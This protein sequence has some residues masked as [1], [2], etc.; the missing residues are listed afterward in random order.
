[1]PLI[2]PIFIPH[3][4][5]PRHCLFCNQVSISGQ[6]TSKENDAELVRKTIREWLERSRKHRKVQVAFY[7]GSFTCLPE[8][9][10]HA[11]LTAVQPFIQSGEVASIRL[12]TRPDCIDEKICDFLKEYGVKTVELGV[13]SLD[14]QVLQAA[15]R[16]HSREDSIRSAGVLKENGLRLGIQLMPGLPQENSRSWSET[17]AQV[18]KLKPD[19]IRLYPTLVI[20]GSGLADLHRNGEFLPMSMNRA[21]A[22]C[23]KAKEI[24]DEAGIRTI[25]MGLQASVSLEKELLAGPYHPSF[26]EFVVA[27]QWFRRARRLLALCPAGATITL[28]IADRDISAFVGPKRINMKRFHELEKRESKMLKFETDTTLSR[29]TLTYVIA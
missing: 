22:Y 25:R 6:R 23:C 19:C 29:G 24:F 2:I 26:G 10:Q 11:F 9:R 17:V 1:M 14:D 27:R 8:E 16:G 18:V 21:I 28:R 13:Q 5:C 7:G 15:L 3:Q 20:A 12:S 4:G